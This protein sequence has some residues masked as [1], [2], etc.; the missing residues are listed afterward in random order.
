MKSR[1]YPMKVSL[2]LALSVAPI[3]RRIS[4]VL[5]QSYTTTSNSGCELL[6][7]AEK[8]LRSFWRAKTEQIESIPG[9]TP[10]SSPTIY[11]KRKQQPNECSIPTRHVKAK[12]FSY[13]F[14]D[15]LSK[16]DLGIYLLQPVKGFKQHLW[17]NKKTF[18]KIKTCSRFQDISGK[19]IQQNILPY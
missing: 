17:F 13:P 8:K 15:S 19:L 9:K 4:S 10:S 11:P 14:K 12:L 1:L 18:F 3:K 5:L 16:I 2:Y 7:P 6:L